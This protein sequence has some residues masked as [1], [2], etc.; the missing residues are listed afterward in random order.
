MARIF[1][2]QLL[3]QQFVQGSAA[4]AHLSCPYGQ[5]GNKVGGLQRW[6]VTV[7]STPTQMS[8]YSVT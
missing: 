5:R 6:G 7:L 8:L 2:S 3:G 4:T 1:F